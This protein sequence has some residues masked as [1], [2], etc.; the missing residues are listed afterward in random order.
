[1]AKEGTYSISKQKGFDG[2]AFR[3]FYHNVDKTHRADMN[4]T[5]RQLNADYRAR[6]IDSKTYSR[7]FDKAFNNYL[8]NLHNDL[9][10]G[11]KQYGYKYYLEKRS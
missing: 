8:I 7:D 4:K 11:Q 9:L 1:M 2:R 5:M 10:D 6:K 3:S